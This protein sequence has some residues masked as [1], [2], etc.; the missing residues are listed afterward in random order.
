M[1]CQIAILAILL[2]AAPK[3]VMTQTVGLFSQWLTGFEEKRSTTLMPE[4]LDTDE[5]KKVS[6]NNTPNSKNI[7]LPT[8]LK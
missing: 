1:F 3:A 6:K 2:M 5:L 7:P 4:T 8:S